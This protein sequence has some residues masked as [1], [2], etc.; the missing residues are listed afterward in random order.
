LVARERDVDV[1]PGIDADVAGGDDLP[2]VLER[3]RR[4]AGGVGGKRGRRHATD[5]EAGVGCAVR[6]ETKNRELVV[7]ERRAVGH[8]QG[9]HD[10]LPVG[11]EGDVGRVR[12]WERN[13]RDAARSEG[14]VERAGSLEAHDHHVVVDAAGDDDLAVGLNGDRLRNVGERAEVHDD[15][16]AGA[17]TGVER[18]V[19]IVAHDGHVDVEAG[20][21]VIT[22]DDDL[23]VR[24]Q[25]H[26]GRGVLERTEGRRHEPARS[27]RQVGRTVGV[28]PP[29]AEVEVVAV[30]EVAGGDELPVR[31]AC[32]RVGHAVVAAVRDGGRSVH[33]ERRIERAARGVAGEREVATAVSGEDDPAIR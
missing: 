20:L 13:G 25:R 26:V 6:H 15:R 7:E 30:R 4:R 16:A 22:H 28:V 17:E 12:R 9:S 32:E 14:G 21:E 1:E 19:G 3:E 10:D 2:V 8:I 33:A 27:E 23:A 18:A 24:L 5:P 31:L 11:C 29:D